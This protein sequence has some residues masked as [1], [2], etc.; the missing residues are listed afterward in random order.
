M[1][2]NENEQT[3]VREPI[4]V[5]AARYLIMNRNGVEERYIIGEYGSVTEV[6]D[7]GDEPLVPE[8]LERELILLRIA[9]ALYGL[10]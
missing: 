10:D 8:G 6:L 5:P 7:N 2:E 1:G 9:A 3:P 4:T